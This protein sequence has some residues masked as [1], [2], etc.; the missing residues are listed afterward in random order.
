MAYEVPGFVYSC[1]SKNDI[2]QF[3]AVVINSDG[4]V[5]RAGADACP[6]D[7]VAQMPAATTQP[8]TI[9]I[10]QIGITFAIAGASVTAGDFVRV[11][12]V[13]RFIEVANQSSPANHV[14][15]ALTSA[16]TN[17]QFALLLY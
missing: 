1:I 4:E 2:E 5:E 8:E 17:E 7:G 12:S 13:G 15:K 16:G 3:R 9:R 10:M 6:I 11:D 14:G